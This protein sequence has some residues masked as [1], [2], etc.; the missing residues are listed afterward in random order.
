[1]NPFTMSE[2]P[3]IATVVPTLRNMTSRLL[4]GTFT[5]TISPLAFS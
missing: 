5:L 2:A 4:I 1:M 3:T